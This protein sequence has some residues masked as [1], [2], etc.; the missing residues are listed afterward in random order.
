MKK[1]LSFLKDNT[2]GIVINASSLHK[3]VSYNF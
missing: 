1:E 2:I 3:I